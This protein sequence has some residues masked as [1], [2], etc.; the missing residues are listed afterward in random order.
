MTLPIGVLSVRD[1]TKSFGSTP[2]LR[3]MSMEVTQG[4]VVCII[5]PSGSGKTTLLRCIAHL[6]RIDGGIIEVNGQAIGYRRNKKGKVVEDSDRN[7]AQARRAVGFVFQRFNLFPH[8]TALENI[9]VGPLHVLGVD[10]EQARSEAVVL[11]ERVGLSD[12]GGNYPSE[13]SGG[14]QQRVAIAR[15]L[16]M[17]PALMLFD[18]PTSALDPEMIDEVLLVMRELALE[19]RTM[20]VVSHEMGFVRGAAHRLVVMDAGQV[21]EDGPPEQVFANPRTERTRRFLAKVL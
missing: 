19:N 8:L 5:G 9:T 20:V 10:K 12:K 13:L 14:Q 21:L 4:E 15:V 7:V 18:E 11:L 2:V 1:V 17:R 3:G 6:E 16:A